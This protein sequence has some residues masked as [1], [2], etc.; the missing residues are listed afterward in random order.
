MCVW[1]PFQKRL[2]ALIPLL[3][4][5]HICICTY[6]YI[7][8]KPYIYMKYYAYIHKV[9]GTVKWKEGNK[10][11]ISTYYVPSTVLSTLHCKAQK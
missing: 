10:H 2:C 3:L 1:D 11:L 4:F 6:K 9:L 8:H 7:Y 5:M